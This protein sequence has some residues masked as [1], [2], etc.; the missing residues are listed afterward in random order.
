MRVST[1]LRLLVRA[2]FA[3]LVVWMVIFGTNSILDDAEVSDMELS[4]RSET[5]KEDLVVKTRI[6][7][8]LNSDWVRNAT[9]V[10][11]RVTTIPTP[12]N[13]S[14]LPFDQNSSQQLRREVLQA[15]LDERIFNLDRFELS[16]DETGIIIVVQVH[17]RSEYLRAC[18]NALRRAKGIGE[19]LLILSHDV[20]SP[21]INDLVSTIDFCPV[22]QIFYPFSSQLY[23]TEFPGDD[24]KDCPKSVNR[25][26]A[27]QLHCQNALNPDHFGN[28][29]ESAFTQVK[30]HWFW[31]VNHV[32]DHLK[33]TRY[34]GG[35]VL[36]IEEDNYV[37]DD[38]LHV[39]QLMQRFRNRL[40]SD[41]DLLAVG[42][43]DQFPNSAAELS[44]VYVKYWIAS[45]HNLG[46][47]MD[48]RA[49]EKIKGCGRV[50]CSFDDYNWD[51]S[52]NHLSIGCLKSRLKVL[53][54]KT[55]RIQHIG[56]C[57]LHAKKSDCSPQQRINLTE[58]F[59]R[60]NRLNLFPKSLTVGNVDLSPYGIPKM[61][62]GWG[63]PRDH[64]LCI[65][66]LNKSLH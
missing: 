29:R 30:H 25:S 22:M 1:R 45:K 36:F 3:S 33:V 8:G 21:E 28:Y 61:N 59:L 4:S 57:G 42:G 46:M 38:F 19:V 62:G 12:A 50:F 2:V 11:R 34:F 18:L 55:P 64:K 66:F 52:L 37:F 49:W 16:R 43:Y 63:D 56:E 39:L 54:I 26:T 20:T 44:Q 47:A 27:V 7:T 35:T 9:G 58:S 65:S 15:N 17:N 10:T 41:C 13:V 24:P 14:K 5:E 31:K 32:F 48:R 23:P 60:Q 40:C 51:W 53:A 6:P